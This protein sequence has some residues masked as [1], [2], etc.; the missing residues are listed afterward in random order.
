MGLI[1]GILG[2]M[3]IP[4]L[5][6]SDP[7]KYGLSY[8]KDFSSC[9]D[10]CRESKLRWAPDQMNQLDSTLQSAGLSKKFKYSNTSVQSTDVIEDYYNGYDHLYADSVKLYAITTHGGALTTESGDKTYYATYC[11]SGNP[12]YSSN[13]YDDQ[14]NMIRCL[15]TSKKMFFNERT[16]S[17]NNMYMQNTGSLRWLILSTCNSINSGPMGYWS[18]RFTYG[19]DYLLGYKNTMKLGETTDECLSDFASHAFGGNSKFKKVWFSGNDD[20]WIDNT[21]GVFTCGT[22]TAPGQADSEY[23]R[24]NYR[25]DW[26]ERIINA[27]GTYYC[28]WSWHEG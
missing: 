10:G 20:W 2:F 13:L 8:I 28:A 3:C 5:C 26:G 15:A 19:L 14:G 23:R 24:D 7:W 16:H 27:S 4:S 21:A 17:S 12:N 25:K 1:Y 6:F 18:G 22:L 11:S 9:A